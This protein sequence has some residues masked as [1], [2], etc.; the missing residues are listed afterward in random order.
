MHHKCGNCAPFSRSACTISAVYMHRFR[1]RIHLVRFID[2]KQCVDRLKTIEKELSGED[3]EI[4]KTLESAIKTVA[5][6]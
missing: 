3:K 1:R 6:E 5:E 4:L 2:F